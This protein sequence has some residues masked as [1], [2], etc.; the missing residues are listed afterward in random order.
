MGFDKVRRKLAQLRDLK[1]VILDGLRVLTATQAGEQSVAD[2][3][4]NVVHL[5]LSRNL[6][7]RLGPVVDICTEM[8]ALRRLALK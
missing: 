6:L 5:D 2:T 3:C 7:E 8:R 4:P 1:I